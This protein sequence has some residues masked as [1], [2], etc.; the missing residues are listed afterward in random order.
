MKM[1]KPMSVTMNAREYTWGIRFLLFQQI[2]MVTILQLVLFLIYPQISLAG[3]NF[4]YYL[5]NFGIV[6][7][8]FRDFLEKSWEYAC[9]HTWLILGTTI[10]GFILYWPTN[11]GLNLILYRYF[12]HYFSVNDAAISAISQSNMLLMGV[13]TVLLVPLAEE[14]LFRGLVFGFLRRRSRILAYLVSAIFFASIHVTGYI[15]SYEAM[16]LLVCL[17]RYIPVS[18]ILAGVYDISGSI[19]APVLIHTAINAIGTLLL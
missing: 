17:L 16:H 2:F 7:F 5:L 13:G 12:P 6:V 10:A 14:L 9:R 3:L 4:I 8:I 18:L 15:G 11:I 1:P 19:I